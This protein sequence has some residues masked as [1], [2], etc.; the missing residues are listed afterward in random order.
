[1]SKLSFKNYILNLRFDVFT[2]VIV[3]SSKYLLHGVIG[4]SRKIELFRTF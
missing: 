1:M 2:A 3:N 4:L